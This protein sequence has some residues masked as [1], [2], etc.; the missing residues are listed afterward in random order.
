MIKIEDL[1]YAPSWGG[2]I[3]YDVHEELSREMIIEIIKRANYLPPNYE[4]IEEFTEKYLEYPL[5]SF[6]RPVEKLYLVADKK[7]T[8][9]VGYENGEQIK[10]KLS[11]EE[12]SY[13]LKAIKEEDDLHLSKGKYAQKREAYLEQSNKRLYNHLTETH[14]LSENLA[15]CQ[16]NCD[17]FTTDTITKFKNDNKELKKN[18][19]AEYIRAMNQCES[20][21]ESEAE[22]RFI[23][24]GYHYY[25]EEDYE[26][27]ENTFRRRIIEDAQGYDANGDTVDRDS[28]ITDILGNYDSVL[29]ESY[30]ESIEE[31]ASDDFLTDLYESASEANDTFILERVKEIM[32]E[33]G[34]TA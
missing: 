19:F 3:V 5:V 31:E 17:I 23:Y 29:Y 22:R 16:K 4:S 20:E 11:A 7:G 18:D 2:Y 33:R 12:K 25:T 24:I 6:N 27:A 14:T 8:L 9:T 1:Y 26:F 34:I 13:I 30:F 21:T 28:I 10:L 15:E 32:S